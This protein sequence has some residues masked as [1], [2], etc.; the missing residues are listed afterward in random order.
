[1]EYLNGHDL[2]TFLHDVRYESVPNPDNP[3]EFYTK[4]I[5]GAQLGLPWSLLRFYMSEMINVLEYL[6]RYVII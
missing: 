6:H 4:K 3:S 2:W 5:V 1:M